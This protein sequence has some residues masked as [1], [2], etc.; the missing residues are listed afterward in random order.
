M[1]KRSLKTASCLLLMG[2]LFN[3]AMSQSIPSSKTMG[4]MVLA[5]RYFMD[6]WPEAGKSII[7]DKERPSNIWTRAVY[8]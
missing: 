7:T 2:C 3:L 1:N 6:K 4:T 5:N 8:Y